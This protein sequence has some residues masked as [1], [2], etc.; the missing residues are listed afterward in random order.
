MSEL[1]MS[2]MKNFIYLKIFLMFYYLFLRY[3]E[4]ER[5]KVLVGEEQRKRET[6]NPKQAPGPE[7]SAQ[8][9]TWVLNSQTVRS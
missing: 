6:Q 8:C 1:E 4:R 9:L 2:V 7:L 5:D 3:I